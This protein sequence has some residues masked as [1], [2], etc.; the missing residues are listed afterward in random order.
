MVHVVRFNADNMVLGL[1]V[2]GIVWAMAWWSAN[3][4]EYPSMP[5]VGDIM[6]PNGGVYIDRSKSVLLPGPKDHGYVDPKLLEATTRYLESMESMA[7][8][9]LVEDGVRSEVNF[10]DSLVWF[11][12]LL[13]S[14]TIVQVIVFLLFIVVY[15]TVIYVVDYIGVR[16]PR[17]DF[18]P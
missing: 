1:S 12:E 14:S 18:I 5:A 3:K 9:A 7:T 16:V 2:V 13:F 11:L 4:S 17:R 15:C 6:M 10:T 8:K